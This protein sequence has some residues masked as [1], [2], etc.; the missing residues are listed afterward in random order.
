MRYRSRTAQ[1][2]D[3]T[4]GTAV[5]APKKSKPRRT[6]EIKQQT[7]RDR[8]ADGIDWPV[9]AWIVL[10]HAGLVLAPFYFTW[11]ALGLCAVLVWLTGSVG[12]CMGYHRC[13]THGS[14]CTYQPIRWLLALCG[15]LSGEGSALMWVANHRQHHLF[16]DKDGDPHSPRDG[17]WWAHLL[18]FMPALS[19]ERWEAHLQ[20][21]APDMAKDPMLRFLHVMFLPTHILLGAILLAAGW[22]GWDGYTGMSF[23]AWGMSVRVVYVFH[24]TWFVNSATHLWGYRNYETSDDS[25]NLWWVGLLAFGEGWHN[26]HHAFQRMARQGHR[27]W[28]LDVTYWTILAMEKLG[29]AWNVVKE[30]GRTPRR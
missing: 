14:F 18:W 26:N 4:S 19:R 5:L 21:Y 11:K 25:R 30:P 3:F 27:W 2:F 12:V 28:E 13:L 22:L 16:S 7:P 9:V 8:W 1:Q 20:R 29:L 15:Q 24:A 17:V 23:L 10:A 6:P